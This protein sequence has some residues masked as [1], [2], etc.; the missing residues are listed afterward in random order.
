MPN[1]NGLEFLEKI[2]RLRPMPVVMVS[3][4]TQAGAEATLQALELGAVDCVA[5]PTRV[6]AGTQGLSDLAERVKVAASAHVRPRVDASAPSARQ[7]FAPSG[8]IVAIGA[9]TG[10]VEALLTVLSH[11]PANCPPTVITQHMPASFTRNFAA[12][13]DRMTAAHVQEAYDGAPLELGKVYLAPGGEA[14]L[15]VVRTAGLRCRLRAGEPVSGHRPSVDALFASV[16]ASAGSAAIGVI[17]TGMGRDGAEA[18]ATMR[19]AGART[20]GQD[21]ASSVVYGM[22]RA[23][24]E[25]GAVEVQASIDAIGPT[26]LQL[27]ERRR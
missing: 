8:S 27:A 7:D 3:T 1:M 2:M 22:P 16:A 14:H 21:A 23:A 10:G 25:I 26:I 13:L 18:L 15:E 24:F 20:L 11:F 4:L 17:L 9:S 19:A 6:T 5:K 12:R